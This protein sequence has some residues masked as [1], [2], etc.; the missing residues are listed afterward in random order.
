MY[1]KLILYILILNIH[2]GWDGYLGIGGRSVTGQ[3]DLCVTPP[4][5]SELM[6]DK[7][8]PLGDDSRIGND[9]RDNFI[10]GA[11]RNNWQTLVLKDT[12]L[13]DNLKMILI[14]VADQNAGT[15]TVTAT[16]GS[17]TKTWSYSTTFIPN[18]ELFLYIAGDTINTESFTITSIIENPTS[19][20]VCNDDPNS[21]YGGFS[22]NTA[23]VWG[24]PH[25]TFSIIYK[26][27]L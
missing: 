18:Q 8:K 15:T 11:S 21:C 13:G 26:F 6:N 16:K 25:F 10:N 23:T 4:S 27:S 5:G 3:C 24:D 7:N 17:A 2:I 20:D 22:G 14:I 12:N 9:P 1:I 19:N